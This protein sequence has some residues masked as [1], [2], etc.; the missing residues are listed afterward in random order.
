MR[1]HF[2]SADKSSLLGLSLRF[3]IGV[4]VG[5]GLSFG[6]VPNS[7]AHTYGIVNISNIQSEVK[8][9]KALLIDVRTA[10]EYEQ[11]HLKH[12]HLMPFDSIAANINNL[13]ED[14]NQTIYLYCRSGLRS[15]MAKNTLDRLGFKN[16]H[17]MGA[18]EQLKQSG[19]P[20][21]E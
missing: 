6:L 19:L 16:V 12:A 2:I 11:G 18:Y 8:Q 20:A 10:S 14:K 7:F 15:G 4:I 9:N 5:M 3:S 1:K 21:V 17:N 13:T